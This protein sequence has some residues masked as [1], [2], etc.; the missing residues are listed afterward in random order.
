MAKHTSKEAYF[1]RLQNLAEVNKTS[2]KESKIRNLGSLI[3]YK[4][5]ADGVAY[6]IVKENHLYYLKKAGT[7]QDPNV[8]DFAYIGGLGNITNFQYKS[9]SEADKQRNMIFHTINEAVTLKPNKTSS[10][11]VLREDVAEK[12]IDMAAEKIGDLDAATSAEEMP[13]EPE[14]SAK[15]AAGLEE[16]GR[17]HV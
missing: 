16:I 14:G 2:L 11:M 5:A 17:A 9:L 6:G 3:D 12:E 15:M 7:K 4:R 1:Q 10:K 13:A 8:S